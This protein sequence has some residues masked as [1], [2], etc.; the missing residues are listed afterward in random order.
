MLSFIIKELNSDASK[1]EEDHA[2]GKPSFGN[3]NKG[4]K[5]QCTGK[6]G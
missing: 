2:K 1:T 5:R 6:S 4:T 3:L